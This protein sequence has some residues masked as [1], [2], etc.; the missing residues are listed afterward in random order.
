M[1]LTNYMLMQ[2]AE[3]PVV[4]SDPAVLKVLIGY[5]S[6]AQLPTW[7]DVWRTML[8]KYNPIWNKDGTIHERR[9]TGF[10]NTGSTTS[11][12]TVTTDQDTSDTGT[13][14]TD[15][16]TTDTGTVGRTGSSS[17]STENQ[18]TGYDTNAYSPNKK[19][20]TSGSASETTTNNLAGT[21]DVTETHN[22]HGTN[23]TTVTNN[24]AGT[25]A[26][27]G[28]AFDV[29]ERT[30]TGNI[31]VTTTQQMIKEQREIALNFYDMICQAFKKQFCVMVW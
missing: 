16:D 22:L 14:V 8:Y 29:F 5:W 2:L 10:N 13:I 6:A 3:L 4:Y 27:G 25:S 11:T 28:T 23:D 24:L 17:G 9:D 31:G 1:V 15:Q 30:E 7:V 20:L 21:N 19:D 12:G 18:V 26:E